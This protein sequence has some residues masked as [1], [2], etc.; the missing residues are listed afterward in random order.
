MLKAL[1]CVVI[2]V[3]LLVGLIGTSIAAEETQATTHPTSGYLRVEIDDDIVTVVAR[4]VSVKNILDEITRQSTLWVLLHSPLDERVTLALHRLPLPEVLRRV[5]GDHIFALHYARPPSSPGNSSRSRPNRL[6]VYSSGRADEGGDANGAEN[7]LSPMTAA[8]DVLQ[9]RQ[10]NEA[11]KLRADSVVDSLALD[12]EEKIAQLT[13]ELEAE[14]KNSRIDAVS[15]LADIGTDEAAETLAM[16]LND[17]NPR[18]R[19]EVVQAL[20]KIGGE[21]A[22]QL[23]EQA[24][25]DPNEHV[26]EAAIEA[27][28]DIGGEESTRALAIALRAEDSAL[29]EEAVYALGDIGGNTATHLI[30]QALTDSDSSVREAAA[31]LLSELPPESVELKD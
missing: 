11:A 5:L 2:G 4:D 25:H 13:F 15:E 26:R 10:S 17:N 7:S 18:V 21:V 29:R 19:E 30:R 3:T 31:E 28:G 24:F 12:M 22:I 1:A 6:W 20:R 9:P 23:L 27:L 16:P 14:E 8:V